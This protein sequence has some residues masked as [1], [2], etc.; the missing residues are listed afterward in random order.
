M[1]ESGEKTESPSEL[2][3]K[4]AR[5]KGQV[6][7]SVDVTVLA[8]IFAATCAI[9]AF[10]NQVE[11]KVRSLCQRLL[12]LDF[13]TLSA[14]KLLFLLDDALFLCFLITLPIASAAGLGAIIG[15]LFQFGFLFSSHPLKAD[16][17]KIN[18]ISGFKKLFSKAR[19]VDLL[20]Q[21]CKFLAL[22][23]VV[24]SAISARASDICRLARYPLAKSLVIVLAILKNIILQVFLVFLVIAFI[25]FFW[26]RF[27][28]LK[29]MRMSKYEV[30]KE[31]K[32]QEGDPEIKGERKRMHREA[33]EGEMKS[34]VHDAAVVI[35]NP[36][37]IAIA[38]RYN[39]NEDEA[40]KI[41]M[42]GQGARAKLI[43]Q[44]A[45]RYSVPILR[46]VPLARDL[47]WL[48]INE[49]IP[50]RLYEA[51]AEVLTFVVELNKKN[52]AQS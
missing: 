24:F 52:G 16:L 32:Q 27:S 11:E 37:H 13:S 36:S 23:Y 1:S 51:V 43:I 49:E 6:A 46:N 2:K 19:F 42:K 14:Q 25:D 18:P 29:S 26:Q 7:K 21:L 12:S 3:L 33:L 48:D 30:K 28:F 50:E 40:P 35:T 47:Q 20:K 45:N 34:H 31:Y 9:L 44:D 17:K 10:F 8:S 15:S 5:N 39:E 41:L 4:E 22:F 38:I